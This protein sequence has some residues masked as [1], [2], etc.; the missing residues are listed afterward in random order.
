MPIRGEC[1]ATLTV[2]IG[3]P[4]PLCATVEQ[5]QERGGKLTQIIPPTDAKDSLENAGG[6]DRIVEQK[7]L[8]A[9]RD[10]RSW[11][12]RDSEPAELVRVQLQ[13]AASMASET[14][15]MALLTTSVGRVW[16]VRF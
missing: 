6:V 8:S 4:N 10:R 3:H 16:D 2:P 13:R 9:N 11:I 15:R 14:S 12:F 7:P 1:W 5:T